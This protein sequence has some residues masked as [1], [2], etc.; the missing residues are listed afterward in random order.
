MTLNRGHLHRT[1]GRIGMGNR[2]VKK[3]AHVHL[4]PKIF[5]FLDAEF[6]VDYDFGIKHDIIHCGSIVMIIQR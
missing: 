1:G 2:G 5:E 6:N 4:P 3:G